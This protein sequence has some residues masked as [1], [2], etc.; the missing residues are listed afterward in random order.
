MNEQFLSVIRDPEKSEEPFK[1]KHSA[2]RITELE[3][4][5]AVA[6]E[7]TIE[8]LL[9]SDESHLDAVIAKTP[10]GTHPLYPRLHGP[11]GPQSAWKNKNSLL[12]CVAP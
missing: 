1:V 12:R 11:D 8:M 4:I 7:Y 2:A 3:A 5:E 6:K 10:S 9:D